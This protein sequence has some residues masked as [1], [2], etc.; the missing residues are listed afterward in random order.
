MLKSSWY[1][2]VAGNLSPVSSKPVNRGR[3]I[4]RHRTHRQLWRPSSLIGRKP[5]MAQRGGA[6]AHSVQK[7]LALVGWFFQR[8]RKHHFFPILRRRH[9]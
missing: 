8:E 3:C 6:F 2:G 9:G 7:C 4:Y 1:A 5:G